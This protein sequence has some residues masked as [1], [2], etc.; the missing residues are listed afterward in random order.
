MRNI[1]III[2]ILISG[3]LITGCSSKEKKGPNYVVMIVDTSG[4]IKNFNSDL[5][6]YANK[7]LREY[8]DQGNLKLTLINL[9]EK[10][11]V[12]I[13]K[14]GELYR[15]D[16]ERILNH[17]KTIEYKAK[18][19]DVIGSIELAKQYYSYEKI[20]P[21]SVKILCFTDGVIEGPAGSHYKSWEEI[22]LSFLNEG[23][24]QIGFYFINP[25]VRADVEKATINIRKVIIKNKNDAL[26][27]LS[28]NDIVLPK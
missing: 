26:E 8:A 5:I 10:P 3:I 4:S 25:E 11:T 19:T 23:N 13:Q 14:E 12:E 9:N 16:I 6:K 21:R 7:A 2:S 20:K 22:D 17:I 1:I 15:E 27:D 24:G 28:Q 18:G